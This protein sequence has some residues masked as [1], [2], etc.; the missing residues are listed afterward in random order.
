[1]KSTTRCLWGVLLTCLLATSFVLS[2]DTEDEFE[3]DDSQIETEDDIPDNDLKTAQV[4]NCIA[5]WQLVYQ[6][7]S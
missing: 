1:M 6:F 3:D 4:C 5:I 2:D 7:T